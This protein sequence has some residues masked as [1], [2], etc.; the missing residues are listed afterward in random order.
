MARILVVDDD[1]AQRDA[2]GKT[3]NSKSGHTV[4]K[5]ASAEEALVLMQQAKS[6]SEPFDLLI[7]DYQMPGMSGA[8][9]IQTVRKGR[10]HMPVIL[11]SGKEIPSLK[12]ALAESGVT[13]AVSFY[14][15][16]DTMHVLRALV[17]YALEPSRTQVQVGNAFNG[18]STERVPS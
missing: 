13:E 8:E 3:L 14:H 9:L 2:V 5:A 6:N 4:H 12:Q 7:T 17:R 16:T 11:M 1:V 15:K 10:E 18:Q